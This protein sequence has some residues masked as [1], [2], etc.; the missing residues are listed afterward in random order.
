M[1]PPT[2]NSRALLTP[3]TGAEHLSRVSLINYF[4]NDGQTGQLEL[5]NE[6]DE[7]VSPFARERRAP[8]LICCHLQGLEGNIKLTGEAHGVGAFTIRIEDSGLEGLA[9]LKTRPS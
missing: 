3:P 7:E 1:R 4:G 9:F 8:R 5:E 6:E 2:L